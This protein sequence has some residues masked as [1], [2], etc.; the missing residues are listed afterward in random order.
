MWFWN[1]TEKVYLLIIKGVYHEKIMFY[2]KNS[3]L[4]S[5]R[6]LL[7][8]FLPLTAKKTK[9]KKALFLRPSASIWF[10]VK[11]IRDVIEGMKCMAM[12]TACERKMIFAI[13]FSTLRGYVSV[14]TIENPFSTRAQYASP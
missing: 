3:I 10:V 4:L 7:D 2:F 5:I 14:Q 9:D 1:F 8:F 6:S 13:I 11:S 12:H